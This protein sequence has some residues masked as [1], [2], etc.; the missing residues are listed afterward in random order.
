MCL[1]EN[2]TQRI[3]ICMIFTFLGHAFYELINVYEQ[4]GSVFRNMNTIAFRMDLTIFVQNDVRNHVL[5][6]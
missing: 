4:R 3:N 1:G 6:N 5:L 2:A